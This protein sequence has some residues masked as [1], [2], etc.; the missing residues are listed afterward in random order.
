[1][2]VVGTTETTR[3]SSSQVT[4]RIRV[5]FSPRTFESNVVARM[6]ERSPFVPEQPQ[7]TPLPRVH[8]LPGPLGRLALRRHLVNHAA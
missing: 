7:G 6:G 3:P 4:P 5:F 8:L 1:M 2:D